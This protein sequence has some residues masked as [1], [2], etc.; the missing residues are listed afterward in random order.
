[1]IAN[2]P[3]NIFGACSMIRRVLARAIS[4]FF[5]SL[6]GMVHD[7]EHVDGRQRFDLGI[8][9]GIRGTAQCVRREHRDSIQ[10]DETGS[11]FLLLVGRVKFE[12]SRI[13]VIHGDAGHARDCCPANRNTSRDIRSLSATKSRTLRHTG[14]RHPTPNSV[15]LSQHLRCDGIA[16][17]LSETCVLSQSTEC[18][19][20]SEGQS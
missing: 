6:D 19:V 8:L 17:Q 7:P 13:Q 18:L 4:A 15:L 3:I 10:F 1:M 12:S 5:L 20:Q 16:L 2:N 14:V 11:G 9:G